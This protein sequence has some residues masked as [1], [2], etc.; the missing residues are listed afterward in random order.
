MR[1]IFEYKLDCIS[2]IDATLSS[3]A[4]D[5]FLALQ[6]VGLDSQ[7]VDSCEE[8]P[9]KFKRF[10]KSRVLCHYYNKDLQAVE[11]TIFKT[12]CKHELDNSRPYNSL[13]ICSSLSKNI[14]HSSRS[15]FL[16]CLTGSTLSGKNSCP[17]SRKF[18]NGRCPLCSSQKFDLMHFSS[19]AVLF[20]HIGRIF[21]G[22]LGLNLARIFL[23][24]Q[25]GNF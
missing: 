2:S 9:L 20:N 4:Y 12:I 23:L 6:K 5:T 13:A 24:R 25:N 7:F 19:T 17:F 3:F 11:S 8:S 16:N 18:G 22:P 14:N 15:L 1:N 21:S 10:I